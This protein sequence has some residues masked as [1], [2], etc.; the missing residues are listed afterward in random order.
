MK[1]LILG[2][3]GH[4]DHGKTALVKALTGI[5]TDRLEE[6][7]RRGLTIDLGFAQMKVG[8]TLL[9]LVDMPGHSDYLRNMMAGASGVDMALL[10]VAAD[11]GVMPQTREHLRILTL[12]G[13]TRLLVALTRC[14]LADR[15]LRDLARSDAETLL[16]EC[17]F[18]GGTPIIEV[19][20]QT[21]E[22]LEALREELEALCSH[23]PERGRNKPFYM[24]IDRVF[25]IQGSGTVVTGAVREGAVAVGDWVSLLPRGGRYRV[26]GLQS[27]G[28]EIPMAAAG[29][30]AAL[31]LAG[32]ERERFRRGDVLSA[33]APDGAEPPPAPGRLQMLDV[34][35]F[36]LPDSG[37][38]VAQNTRLHLYI[39]SAAAVCGVRLLGKKELL[40][41][42]R[43]FARLRLE[44]PVAALAGERFALRFYSPMETIGGGVVV[45]AFPRPFR[46]RDEEALLVRLKRLLEGSLE[47]RILLAAGAEPFSK[48]R[49]EVLFFRDGREALCQAL[50]GLL[51]IG[52][53]ILAGEP[54]AQALLTPELMERLRRV[55]V[56]AVRFW[57]EAH[58]LEEGMPPESL[59][60]AVKGAVLEELLREKALARRERFLFLP[61]FDPCETAAFRAALAHLEESLPGEGIMLFEKDTVMSV[62]GKKG[63]PDR[64]LTLCMRWHVFIKL[65][66]ERFMKR[67]VF[68]QASAVVQELLRREGS[69]SLAEVR[70]ALCTSRKCAGAIL[71]HLDVL[72]V[73]VP[74]PDERRRLVKG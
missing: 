62:L 20:S 33:P 13:V 16:A 64:L 11:E 52:A 7:K 39:G 43:G 25:T 34:Y 27:G 42:E 63:S 56:E 26:R 54:P 51:E 48:E 5:D 73:T 31:N 32:A 6:E 22:G 53:L 18:G 10:T 17:G 71:E 4:V 60:G 38:S 49:L 8:E 61:G 72:G 45:D 1:H 57:Q 74:G 66:N 55:T 65:E 44:S 37:R 15:E 3:A 30:R 70:D 36:L 46:K 19:S 40:P 58:P 14:D 35:L 69:V 12:F 24:C 59:D 9:D 23:T 67:E 28:E 29:R 2:T 68:E 41:G 47:D 50:D 21:G